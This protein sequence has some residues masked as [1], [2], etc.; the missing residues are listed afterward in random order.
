[1]VKDVMSLKEAKK[2]ILKGWEGEKGRAGNYIII[3]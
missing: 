3:L 1:M 2:V